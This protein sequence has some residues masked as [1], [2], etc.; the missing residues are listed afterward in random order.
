M[1]PETGID[2]RF[3]AQISCRGFWSAFYMMAFLCTKTREAIVTKS[4]QHPNSAWVVRQTK[5]FLEQTKGREQKPAVLMHDRD[6]KFSRA[7]VQACEKGGLTTNPLPIASPNLNGRVERF[8]QT[9]KRECLFKFILFGNRHL[10][11]IVEH[12]VVYY[13]VARAHAGKQHL[14]PVG[15]EPDELALP[16]RDRIEIR[17]Y[18]GGLVRSFERKAA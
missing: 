9:I 13:N 14:P 12:F 11:Y 5:A 8:I 2:S 4:T 6:T 18:V 15:P 7:F 17:T 1:A 16:N 10:D 3:M